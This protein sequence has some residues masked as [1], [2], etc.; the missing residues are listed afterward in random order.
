MIDRKD[1]CYSS[2]KGW[3]G[4]ASDRPEVL[5][6]ALSKP[7]AID[8]DMYV[9]GVWQTLDVH[10]DH[11][12][13]ELRRII[14]SCGLPSDALMEILELAAR[15][16]DAGKA[17]P[18]FQKAAADGNPESDQSVVWAKAGANFKRYERRGFRHEL[19]SA[20]AMMANRLPDLAVY[21]A[22]AHHG[23]VRLSIRSLPNEAKPSDPRIRF[24][25]GIWDGDILPECALGGGLKLPDT[26]LDLSSMELGDGPNGPSWLARML[27]LRDDPGIGPFRLAF[28]ESLLRA[29]DRRASMEAT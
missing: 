23:K 6:E 19:A 11:V 16:H 18:V 27:S 8:D 4:V 1:G 20:L 10:A 26:V 7:E 14:A 2:E 3:T 21:L 25:R 15:W 29:A 24:A 9:Q 28:L 22:A 5:N 13:S 12:V 17:H